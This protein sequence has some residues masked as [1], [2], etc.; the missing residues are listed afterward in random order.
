MR[1]V[2]PASQQKYSAE[3]AKRTAP[4]AKPC[5][6]GGAIVAKSPLVRG[7]LTAVFWLAKPDGLTNVVSTRSDAVLC[8][9]NALAA[10]GPL[11][12]H[13]VHLR[14]RTLS[15]RHTASSPLTL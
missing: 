12:P 3:W 7:M 1:D 13:L 4:I 8:A 2:A 5:R 6:L 14:A 9:V 11:L 10:V 15:R